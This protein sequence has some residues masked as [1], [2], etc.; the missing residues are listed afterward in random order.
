MIRYAIENHIPRYNFYG[1]SGNFDKEASDYGV[2]EFKRGF[3]GQVE[4]LL[5]EFILPVN[6]AVYKLYKTVKK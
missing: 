6:K 3:G 4:Q 5:G 1:I 2:Y